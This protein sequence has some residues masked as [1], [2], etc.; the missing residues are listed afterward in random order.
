[1]SVILKAP[2]ESKMSVYGLVGRKRSIY[3]GIPVLS[4]MLGSG[5]EEN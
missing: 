2:I 3:A 5:S 1:M 4:L